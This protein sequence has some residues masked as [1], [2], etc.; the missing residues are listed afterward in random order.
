[1]YSAIRPDNYN[2]RYYGCNS[3]D[4]ADCDAAS[5]RQTRGT[6]RRWQPMRGFQRISRDRQSSGLVTILVLNFQCENY[7]A[8]ENLKSVCFLANILFGWSCLSC[9]VVAVRRPVIKC[10]SQT[11]QCHCCIDSTHHILK[12][13]HQPDELPVHAFKHYFKIRLINYWELSLGG[14]L[15]FDISRCAVDHLFLTCLNGNIAVTY[16]CVNSAM[17]KAVET[18]MK[19]LHI[20]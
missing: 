20:G 10:D 19:H 13:L 15:E 14:M 2:C 12:L 16:S 8:P 3:P 6:Q 5:A 7:T 1:M 18:S 17:H 11:G 4:A 9:D